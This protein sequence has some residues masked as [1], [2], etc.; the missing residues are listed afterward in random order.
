MNKKLLLT[1]VLGIFTICVSN[2]QNKN[3]SEQIS[4]EINAIKISAKEELC[5]IQQRHGDSILKARGIQYKIKIDYDKKMNSILD[6]YQD[7]SKEYFK[8]T[9][10]YELEKR[11]RF[12]FNQ[13]KEI[14]LIDDYFRNK[15][16]LIKNKRDIYIDRALNI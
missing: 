14:E 12:I 10:K 6:K 2:A 3:I 9:Y 15:R 7:K 1:L 4:R 5:I 13:D 16:D 11:N 8:Q